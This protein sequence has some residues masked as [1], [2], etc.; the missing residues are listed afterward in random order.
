M[1]RNDATPNKK[2]TTFTIHK[3]SPKDIKKPT[4][5]QLEIQLDKVPEQPK[6]HKETIQKPLQLENK[7]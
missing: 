3:P 7:E 6:K 4:T 1:L 2:T 5:P